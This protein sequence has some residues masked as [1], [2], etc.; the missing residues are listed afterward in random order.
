MQ[1]NEL[2]GI[3]F[4]FKLSYFP[5][6]GIYILINIAAVIRMRIAIYKHKQHFEIQRII[7]IYK[8]TVCLILR[9]VLILVPVILDILLN[10]NPLRINDISL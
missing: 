10:D 1:Y 2:Y 9:I 4:F 6:E 8:F 3:I 7:C 5:K